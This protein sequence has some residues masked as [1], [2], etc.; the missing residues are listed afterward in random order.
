ME[1][2]KFLA[3]VG[4]TSIG[5]SAILGSGAF[6]RVESQRG[7][8]IQVAEDPDAYLGLDKCGGDDPTPNGSYAHLDGNGHL[9][10][11]LNDDNPHHPEDDLGAGVNS[12]STT[13]FDRV[14]QICNQGKKDVC[15]WIADDTGWPTVGDGEYEGERRVDFYYEDDDGQ[16]IVGFDNHVELEL[17][18]CFCVGLRTRTHGL[19]DGEELLDALENQIT[20]IADTECPE[21]P[22]DD[23][24][25]KPDCVTC[26]QEDDPSRLQQLTLKN[27]GDDDMEIEI[28]GKMT[29]ETLFEKQTV[30]AG[31]EFTI[32][33]IPTGR[34]ELQMAITCDGEKID[35]LHFDN[36]SEDEITPGDQFHISCSKTVKPGEQLFR[37]EQAPNI[38]PKDEPGTDLEVVS[39]I[40]FD[41]N[42]I[43]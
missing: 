17:G 7:V 2:R 25:E 14:F 9:E 29:N 10:L 37:V 40:D 33:D 42:V 5:G 6:S 1:R 13:W 24:P 30:E 35:F 22:P 26:P 27:A 38:D 41:G 11:L 21:V 43:C 8:T 31:E 32:A 23:P 20:I 39:G 18:K 15:V 36:P 16:S 3:G 28:G 12:N 34:P 4:A 19:S